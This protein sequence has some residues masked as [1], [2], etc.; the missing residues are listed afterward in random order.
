MPEHT[1]D[2]KHCKD[3]L[4]DLSLYI[5]YE[6]STELCEEIERHLAECANCNVV[7][8]TLQRTVSLY[9]NHPKP[10][11]PEQLRERLYR[12]FQIEEYLTGLP[13][14]Q[15]ALA[16]QATATELSM[17]VRLNTDFDTALARTVDVLKGQGFGV[18]TEIDVKKTMK[19]KLDVDFRP[20]KILGACNPPLAY[21]ALMAAP[22]V[23]L[24]LPCNVTVAYVED[25]VTE[26]SLINPLSLMRF[27]DRPELVSIANEAHVRLN[28]VVALLTESR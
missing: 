9:R 13:E 22:E 18:L 19:E 15:G 12:T 21:R 6:A 27:V 24:L 4:Q 7:V 23:G 11:M 10:D 5:D 28:R 8:D 14:K 20:Y 3:F 2:G 16:M 17:S 25:R 26:V 1:I